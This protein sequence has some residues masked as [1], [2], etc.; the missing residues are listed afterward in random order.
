MKGFD[1]ALALD[2]TAATDWINR[3]ALLQDMGRH[4]E[5][6]ESYDK[7]LAL[8]PN[9]PSFLINRANALVMLGRLEEAD[10][11]LRPGDRAAAQD[12]SRLSAEGAGGEIPRPLRGGAQADGKR[13]HARAQ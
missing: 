3:G 12:V 2:P 11:G 8:L 4:A 13:A 10:S 6:L 5:A 7:A 9:E 1:R